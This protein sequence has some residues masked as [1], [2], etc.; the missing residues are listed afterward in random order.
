VL[1]DQSTDA[2]FEAGCDDATFGALDGKQYARFDREAICFGAAV[3]SAI[4]DVTRAL[5]GL[6]IV[7]VEPGVADHSFPESTLCRNH[8]K[9]YPEK[10]SIYRLDD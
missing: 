3:S 8:K 6:A 7:R 10:Y 5:P 2:L 1:G 9:P 4:R